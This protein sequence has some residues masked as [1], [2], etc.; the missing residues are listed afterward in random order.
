MKTSKHQKIRFGLSIIQGFAGGMLGGFAYLV[1]SLSQGGGKNLNSAISVLPY[2]FVT[3][4]ILGSIK[5]TIMWIIYRVIDRTP[6]ALVRASISTIISTVL[7][8]FAGVYFQFGENEI[9]S[10]L[11][12]TL[13]LGTLVALM[14]G[15]SVKPWQLFTFGSI[16]AGELDQRVGSRNILATLAS[17]PLRFLGIGI[18]VLF[19]L[20]VISEMQPVNTF[21]K[22]VGTILLFALIGAYPAFSAYVT[23]RSPRKIVLTALGVITNTPIALLGLFAYGNYSRASWLGEAPLIFSQF[24]GSFVVAWM[25]FLI[26]RLSVNVSP[27][28]SPRSNKS[29]A[30]ARNLDREC[31]GS[32]FAE[33][34]QRPA[35][36]GERTCESPSLEQTVLSAHT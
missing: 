14:V 9:T 24:C 36:R 7:L 23:F 28:P 22:I 5:A 17:F 12:P 15:S 4:A 18:T 3:F 33:W 35:Y 8:A 19:L 29:I 26:A 11:L 30:D 1:L 20:Y 6:R 27:S 31:L 13:C 32:R 21:N 10:F 16:A 34:Q 2:F 25:I